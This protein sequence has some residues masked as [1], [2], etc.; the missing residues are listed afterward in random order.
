[1]S[2]ILFRVSRYK[3]SSKRFIF[4]TMVKFIMKY[5]KFELSYGLIIL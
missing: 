3:D 4:H 1:M 2:T 5:I